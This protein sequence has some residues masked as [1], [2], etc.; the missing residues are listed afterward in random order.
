VPDARWLV[1]GEPRAVAARARALLRG[2]LA[3]AVPG[4]HE[5]LDTAACVALA[6]RAQPALPAQA[7]SEMLSALDDAAFAETA[8]ADVAALAGSARRLARE[9]AP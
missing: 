1:A 4:A 8:A 3:R 2:A 7:L 6:T 5:A 9:L